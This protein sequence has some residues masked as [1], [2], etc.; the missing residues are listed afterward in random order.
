MMYLTPPPDLDSAWKS[1]PI[2]S[3]FG[4]DSGNYLLPPR[5]GTRLKFGDHVFTCRGDPD[6]SRLATDKDVERLIEAGRLAYKD[7][8]TYT[9]LERKACYYTVAEDEH[10]VIRPLSARGT[11]LS[12]CSGHGFK[13]GPLSGEEAAQ[14]VDKAC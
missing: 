1:A 9:P 8:D 5:P 12:A 6:A 13:L 2:F 4:N 3:D 10:F 14:L 11:V 7:F